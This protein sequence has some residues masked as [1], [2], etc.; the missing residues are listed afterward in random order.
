LKVEEI[1]DVG[2]RGD[3]AAKSLEAR[4]FI[5]FWSSIAS[6]H[7][8]LSGNAFIRQSVSLMSLAVSRV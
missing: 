6:L 8:N 7:S 5:L 1:F 2:C 3:G 4:S